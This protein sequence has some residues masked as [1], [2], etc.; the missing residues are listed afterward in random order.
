MKQKAVSVSSGPEVLLRELPML[1][2]AKQEV[3]GRVYSNN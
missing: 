3:G 2:E 1:S